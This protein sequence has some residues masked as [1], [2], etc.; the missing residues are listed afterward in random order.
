MGKLFMMDF[1]ADQVK[2]RSCFR[3]EALLEEIRN[4][5]PDRT[6]IDK[7]QEV[8]GELL[9]PPAPEDRPYTFCSVVLS[10]DGKMAFADR[11][12]GPLIARENYFDPSGA[13]ADFW[14]LNALRVYSDGIILGAMTLQNEAHNTSHVFDREMADQRVRQLG[15]TPHPMN[16]VVSFDA[17]DIPFDHILFQVDPQENLPVAVATSPKGLE[18]VRRRCR[19]P[20]L[21]LGPLNDGEPVDGR[22]LLDRMKQ[23]PDSLPVFVTGKE[24]RPDAGM[25]LKVLR[26]MGMERLLIESP[27]Y[28]WHLMENGWLD[29]F[30]INYSMVY[31]GGTITPGSGRPFAHNRHPH[32]RLLTLGTHQSSFMYTRQKLYYGVEPTTDLEGYRY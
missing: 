6:T 31:A 23:E 9:F 15:K 7:I 10:S 26:S 30:F 16:I 22:E 28:N 17:T 14:M 1:P 27:S 4:T 3:D 2:I 8:Y 18:E 11:S 32:A 13:L 25:L 29:E 21:A 19:R 24:N 5:S 20:V 12:A